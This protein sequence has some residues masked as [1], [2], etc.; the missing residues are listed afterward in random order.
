MQFFPEAPEIFLI[1]FADDVALIADTVI[2]LQ[3]Q[4]FVIQ[5]FCD[6]Y[7]IYVNTTKTKI[8][9][10]KNGGKLANQEQWSYKDTNLE[11]VNG[12]HYVGLLFTTQMSLNRMANDLAFKGKKA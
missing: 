6:D 12:F 3:R 8:L 2:G 4:L 1:M 9:V 7:N 11:V 10:F 5:E